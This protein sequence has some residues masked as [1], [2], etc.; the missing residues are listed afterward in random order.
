MMKVD[1]RMAVDLHVMHD[2]TL[3]ED[4]QLMKVYIIIR[5]IEERKIKTM[6]LRK[7]VNLTG[8]DLSQ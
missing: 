7:L 3:I 1:I 4:L 8:N 5:M 2:T 6:K